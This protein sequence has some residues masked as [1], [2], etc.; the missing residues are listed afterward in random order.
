MKMFRGEHMH[1][2]A[3]VLMTHASELEVEAHPVGVM[4]LVMIV[5]L[6]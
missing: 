4:R 6:E 2:N 5:L 1:R 3:S